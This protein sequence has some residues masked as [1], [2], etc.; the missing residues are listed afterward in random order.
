LKDFNCNGKNYISKFVSFS[1]VEIM[2]NCNN[3][4]SMLIKQKF[5]NRKETDEGELICVR[6]EYNIIVAECYTIQGVSKIHGITSGMGSSYVGNK[7]VYINPGPEMH[8]FRVF[9]VCL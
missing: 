4:S 9:K 6:T 1:V 8:S 2:D 7:I 5:K 3:G